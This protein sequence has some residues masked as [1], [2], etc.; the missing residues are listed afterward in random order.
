MKRISL[1]ENCL[2]AEADL[3]GGKGVWLAR[4]YS[5]N[6]RIPKTI[7]LNTTAYSYFIETQGLRE[8]I[9]LE[10]NR[11][12]FKD[13][14]WEEIWDASLRIRNLFLKS[15]FP[16]D[17]SEEIAEFLEM[18]IGDAPAAVRSSAPDEDQQENSYAGLHDSFLN[19][20]GVEQIIHSIKKVWSSLWSDRA[21]LY[22]KELALS[23]A[24][25]S[26][27]VVIQQ[28]VE[29]SVSGICFTQNPLDVNTMTI[30]AVYGL[31]QGLVDGDIEPDRWNVVKDTLA[32]EQHTQPGRRERLAVTAGQSVEI[33][34][35]QP[36][37]MEKPPLLNEE[38]QD[39]SKMMAKL[40]GLYGLP[41]D[42]EWTIYDRV[43]YI[44]QTR[45]ITA[46]QTSSGKGKDE[47]SWYLSLHRSLENLKVL[48][49][50][51]ECS[52]LPEMTA[53]AE[54]LA[55]MNL[56]LLSD[57][58]LAEEIRRRQ[59]RSG[60]W[61][62]LYWRDCIPF[63]HGIRL[64]GEV[65]NDIMI[66]Q[67]PHEFVFLLR[68]ENMLSMQRNILIEE[69]ASHLRADQE[70]LTTLRLSGIQDISN[71]TFIQIFQRLHNEYGGYFSASASDRSTSE[72]MLSK[73]VI[74]YAQIPKNPE[75]RGDDA[76][77][78]K[79]SAFLKKIAS[80]DYGFDAH[81]FLDLARASYRIRDDD[82]IYLGRIENQAARAVSEGK[83]RLQEKNTLIGS[84]GPEDIAN[85]L[86][87]ISIEPSSQKSASHQK[88][89]PTATIMR[90]RQLLGQPASQGI[91]KGKAR[92]IRN[93][94]ELADFKAAEI[95]VIESIDPTMTFFA[96]LAAAIVEQRGGMLIHGA[97]IAREYGIPS[98]T[99]IVHATE[100]IKSGDTLTV[101]G[102]L[103]IVTVDENRPVKS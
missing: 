103:G 83:K 101:D 1:L 9:A 82:N 36:E 70:L 35:L 8:K 20:S 52:M 18:E 66:P 48:R 77:K 40:E 53:E 102:Y 46:L 54:Q 21:L 87:G 38:V 47:R 55:S 51:I 49:N 3:I 62:D 41:L 96:P 76:Q 92:V 25:S 43:T 85:Q 71:Q 42:I 44:L 75:K 16:T 32:I 2:D 7:C 78:D 67:D 34:K 12:E 84:A 97:I 80:S 58:E 15:P 86:C 45:P 28:L 23:V 74:E 26:M 79:E 4:L 99:G 29:G 11:K 37:Q 60:Y 24:A 61:T 69:L 10:L 94:N 98:I 22:R 68:G 39:L 90:A 73:V 63:A 19:I 72:R 57:G 6:I 81:E 31:N 91:A 14:R 13:M 95:L 17:L 89:A 50:T 33:S 59:E 65:Y 56:S 88:S 64:F 100:Y 30:E 93:N 5:H 27:A